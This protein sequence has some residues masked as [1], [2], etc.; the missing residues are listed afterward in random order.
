[1]DEVRAHVR[2]WGDVQGVFFRGGARTVAD[3]RRVTGWI[4]NRMDGS[5]EAVF[6]GKQ[7]DV[8]AVVDWCRTG[9]PSAEVE[10]VEVE[11]LDATG[12]FDHFAVR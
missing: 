5:V 1:M 2:I 12:E 8:E 6:E 9:P 7:P 11:W 4:W 10:R 3:T